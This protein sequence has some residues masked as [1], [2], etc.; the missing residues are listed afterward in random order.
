MAL[1]VRFTSSPSSRRAIP[2][3]RRSRHCARY[4]SPH[5]LL[6]HS[7]AAPPGPAA[8][9]ELTC[10]EP[11]TAGKPESRI[12]LRRSDIGS[13]GGHRLTRAPLTCWSDLALAC[14]SARA[15]GGRAGHWKVDDIDLENSACEKQRGEI[16]APHP[17]SAVSRACESAPP[18][19]ASA[20][21]CGISGSPR[22]PLRS[23]LAAFTGSLACTL[24]ILRRLRTPALRPWTGPAEADH[25]RC[26]SKSRGGAQKARPRAA[27]ARPFEALSLE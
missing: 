16:F 12:H 1:L 9:G 26:P 24:P 20:H 25:A 23:T 8:L 13:C 11:V 6:L 18:V 22:P 27:K 10:V 17:A 15:C 21:R 14:A 2:S 7:K 3:Q 5:A 19:T 4:Q